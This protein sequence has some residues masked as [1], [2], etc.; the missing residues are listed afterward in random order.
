MSDDP[1]N[2]DEHRGMAAQKAT[3][4]RRLLSGVQA[5]QSAAKA[6][7]QEFEEHLATVPATS[8]QEAVIKAKYLV[9]LFAETREGTDPRRA[10]LIARSLEE[11]DQF[12]KL[13]ALTDSTT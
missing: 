1:I 9:Q 13:G 5:E 12:F 11:L 2:L 6:R 10:R 3:D 7:Q 4:L 8:P